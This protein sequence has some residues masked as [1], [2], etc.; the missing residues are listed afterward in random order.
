MLDQRFNPDG[1]I[2]IEKLNEAYERLW[3]K[4][5]EEAEMRKLLRRFISRR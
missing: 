1:S 5:D 3:A 2:N 4:H